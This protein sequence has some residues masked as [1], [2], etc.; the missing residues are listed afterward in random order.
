MRKGPDEDT[1]PYH[2]PLPDGEPVHR[3]V[4][5]HPAG[6]AEYWADV[7]VTAL[8]DDRNGLIGRLCTVRDV[9][10]ERAATA[11][12]AEAD[13]RF[14]V[15]FEHAPL[16]MALV[17]PQ[18]V[19]LHVND[20]LC[21]MLGRAAP[22]VIRLGVS[23]LTH[24]ADRQATRQALSGNGSQVVKRVR[25]A[26]GHFLSVQVTTSLVRNAA[27]EPHYFVGQAQDVTKER[28][29]QS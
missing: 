3:L 27:G 19:L 15:T 13:E 7:V 23:G 25:H 8:I 24:R 17:S 2:L 28:L 12:L 22:E 6:R 1:L 5:H 29:R 10:A 14:R 16:G 26:D 20:A 4:Q 18:G 9:T 21:Q 11:A